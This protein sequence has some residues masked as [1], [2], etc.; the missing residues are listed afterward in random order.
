M[1]RSVASGGFVHHSLRLSRLYFFMIVFRFSGHFCQEK[2]GPACLEKVTFLFFF[3]SVGLSF[4][5]PHSWKEQD[6]PV[7]YLTSPTSHF[8]TVSFPFLSVFL[9]RSLGLTAQ[10]RQWSPSQSHPGCRQRRA[11]V[12]PESV[13]EAACAVAAA[14][15]AGCDDLDI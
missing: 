11:C 1:R 14:G 6:Q 15:S 10:S 12:S 4:V 7:S 3:F 5:S 2:K 13:P 8:A 9:H